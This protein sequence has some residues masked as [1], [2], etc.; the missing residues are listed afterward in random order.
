[1]R[2]LYDPYDSY[3]V[4]YLEGETFITI[5]V[6]A[7][8]NT[9]FYEI[10]NIAVDINYQHQGLGRRLMEQIFT[11]YRGTTM[12]GGTSD[13]PVT[14]SFYRSLGFKYVETKKVFYYQL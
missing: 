6:I 4:G 13:S 3:V 11:D 10:K 7:M 9:H 12:Y 2:Y 1:M 8:R 14:Q 5:A